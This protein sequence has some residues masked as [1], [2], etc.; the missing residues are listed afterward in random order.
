MHPVTNAQLL[1]TITTARA[2]QLTR[3]RPARRRRAARSAG[4]RFFLRRS[5]PKDIHAH[6]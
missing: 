6:A 3:R 1:R 2:D 4:A 5:I